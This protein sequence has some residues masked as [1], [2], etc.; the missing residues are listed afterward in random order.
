VKLYYASIHYLLLLERLQR[1]LAG[2]FRRPTE[3]DGAFWGHEKCIF[4]GRVT[5]V[6]DAGTRRRPPVITLIETA[7][8]FSRGSGR[9][10]RS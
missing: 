4:L 9:L 10:H 3:R 6:L 5:A 8:A 1:D 7:E 2:H